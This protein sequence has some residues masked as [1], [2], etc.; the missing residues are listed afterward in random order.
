MYEKW[1]LGGRN[2]DPW[3]RVELERLNRSTEDLAAAPN[4]ADPASRTVSEGEMGTLV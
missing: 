4:G 1:S 3:C 2:N